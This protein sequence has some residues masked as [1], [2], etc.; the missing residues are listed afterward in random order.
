MT[1]NEKWLMEAIVDNLQVQPRSESDKSYLA[2]VKGVVYLGKKFDNN[3]YQKIVEMVHKE[4]YEYFEIKKKDD[5]MYVSNFNSA[6]FK[7]YVSNKYEV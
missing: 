3:S 1:V 2:S 4:L 6:D 5:P 7:K